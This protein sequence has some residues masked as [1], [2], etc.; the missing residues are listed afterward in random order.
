MLAGHNTLVPKGEVRRAPK[1]VLEFAEL[2]AQSLRRS[3]P[4]LVVACLRFR[5][6]RSSLLLLQTAA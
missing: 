4:A 1:I 6:L 5:G 3:L 2:L